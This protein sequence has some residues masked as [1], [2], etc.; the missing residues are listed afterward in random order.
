[1]P[2]VVIGL[3]EIDMKGGT[4]AATEVTVPEPPDASAAMAAVVV[5][6]VEPPCTT[7]TIS[8]PV[9]VP[10]A[11]KFDIAVLAMSYPWSKKSMPFSSRRKS[12]PFSSKIPVVTPPAATAAGFIAS[13][14]KLNPNAILVN[15]QHAGRVS[16]GSPDANDL[17][18]DY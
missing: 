13:R 11:V 12:M 6:T 9:S 5:R 18:G 14:L 16:T 2:E 15:P 1:V 3:P 4:D 8:V 17:H 10:D 7:G